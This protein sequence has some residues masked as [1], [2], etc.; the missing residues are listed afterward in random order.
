MPDLIYLGL[1]VTEVALP[2]PHRRTASG[3]GKTG[4]TVTF[5]SFEAVDLLRCVAEGGARQAAGI[6]SRISARLFSCL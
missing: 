1:T 3:E 5:R 6:R 4:A 2:C